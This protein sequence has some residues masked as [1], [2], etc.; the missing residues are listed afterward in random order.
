MTQFHFLF[1]VSIKKKILFLSLYLYRHEKLEILTLNFKKIDFFYF[2]MI[3]YTD[4]HIFGAH[5]PINPSFIYGPDIFYIGDNVDLKNCPR[6]K[7]PEALQLI[8]TI[9]TN[10]GN[11]Y[12]PG[13]HELSYGKQLFI[14]YHRVLLTHGDIFFWPQKK[15]ARWRDGSIHPGISRSLWWLLRFKN[16][17]IHMWP[18]RI[19]PLIIKRM[20]G[21]A[22]SPDHH[23]HTVIIGHAHP[24]RII[25]TAYAEKDGPSVD[26]YILPR[27]RHEL[28]IKAT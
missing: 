17:L 7:L 13:N 21:I 12:L 19:S 26:F 27:G 18:I 1:H 4:L 20:Y 14:K 22:T 15:M 23:C 3:V 25:H 6:S 24:H 28:N 9:E 11:N 8:K 2:I 10:A 16:A 5:K